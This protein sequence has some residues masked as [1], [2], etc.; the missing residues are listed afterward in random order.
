MNV[1]LVDDQNVVREAL[2]HTLAAQPGIDLVLQAESGREALATEQLCRCHVAIIELTIT[3]RSGT[4]LIR[5]LKTTSDLRVIVLSIYRD[6]FR[7]AEA[8]RAGA[9]GYLSKQARLSE[10]VEA[11]RT[12]ARGRTAVSADVSAAMVRSLQRRDVPGGDAVAAL[13]ERERQVL[14]LLHGQIGQRGGGAA[15]DQREDGRD[16]PGQALRQDGDP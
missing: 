12:V 8:M 2:A 14:R 13:S 5:Q 3:D 1:L 7:V 16:A 11:L 6:E 9:D 15:L 10:L 4:E